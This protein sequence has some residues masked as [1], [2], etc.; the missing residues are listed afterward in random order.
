[1]KKLVRENKLKARIVLNE[2][3]KPYSYIFLKKENPELIDPDRYTPARKSYDKNYHKKIDKWSKNLKEEL[4]AEHR[5]LQH[6]H[7][8]QSQQLKG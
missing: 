4:L 2:E 6:K 3:G 7:G 5:K 8:R 1:M